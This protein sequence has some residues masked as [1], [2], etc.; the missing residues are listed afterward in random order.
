MILGLADE[1]TAEHRILPHLS[2]GKRGFKTRLDLVKVFQ[3]ILK[4]MKTGC[5]WRELSIKKYFGVDVPCWQT[6]YY[7]FNKR[8][9]DGIALACFCHQIL[10]KIKS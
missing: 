4:R 5:R 1:S 6:V 9:R 8:N 7:H 2:K 3:V 10:A